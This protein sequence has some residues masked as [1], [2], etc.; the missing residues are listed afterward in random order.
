M[1]QCYLLILVNLYVCHYRHIH[2]DAN[3]FK[4][5]DSSESV[6]LDCIA[7]ETLFLVLINFE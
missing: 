5:R 1:I 2:P 6:S 4:L 3:A 7:M